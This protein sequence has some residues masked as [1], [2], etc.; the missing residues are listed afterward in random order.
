[1]HER[2][3]VTGLAAE[4]ADFGAKGLAGPLHDLF[5]AGQDLPGERATP[6]LRRT[7]QVCVE[8]GNDSSPA[9]TDV[10]FPA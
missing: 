4:L 8:A 5:A 6:V 3:H 2:V 7:D 9:F 1:M 10:S